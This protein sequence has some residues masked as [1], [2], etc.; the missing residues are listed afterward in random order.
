MMLLVNLLYE[1]LHVTQIVHTQS[2]VASLLYATWDY[3]F[4]AK[5]KIIF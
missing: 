1:Q 2:K 4:Y 5:I 3:C